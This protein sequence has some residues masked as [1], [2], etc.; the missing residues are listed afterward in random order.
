MRLPD[1]DDNVCGLKSHAEDPPQQH[2]DDARVGQEPHRHVD[3]QPGGAGLTA[4]VPQPFQAEVDHSGV[5]LGHQPGLFGGRQEVLRREQATVRRDDAGECLVSRHRV[6]AQ[7][8]HRLDADPHQTL[9][10]RLSGKVDHAH[11]V[12]GA[13]LE[14]GREEVH[15]VAAPL[16]GQVHGQ[17]GTAQQI[18]AGGRGVGRLSHP[19]RCAELVQPA[20]GVEWLIERGTDTLG[21]HRGL[22]GR[23]Q[24]VAHHHELVASHAGDH[25]VAPH[26][27][28]DAPRHLFEHAVAD[29]VAVGVVDVLEPVEVDEHDGHGA[30]LAPQ[31]RHHPRQVAHQDRT[32]GQARQWVVGG[33]VSQCLFRLAECRDVI[34]GHD[35]HPVLSHVGD[36]RRSQRNPHDS[37]P[38]S[39]HPDL[40]APRRVQQVLET[41]P[42]HH[43][44]IG[45]HEF[46]QS[47][48]QDLVVP[49]AQELQEGFADR[50]DAARLPLPRWWLGNVDHQGRRGRESEGEVTHT[51]P[52]G[53]RALRRLVHGLALHRPQAN[54]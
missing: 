16:L 24:G 34:Q 23:L 31:P 37:P 44:V 6:V 18:L 51:S 40:G 32:V 14:V 42:E 33:T 41:G 27:Q 43:L 3:A 28:A 38:G 9:I 8:E 50:L 47:V 36:V 25:V 48:A 13:V 46:L 7:V 17:V 30:R 12:S 29:P 26:C 45:V 35:Q 52:V 1:F 49:G 19:H 10:Q 53:R 5:D 39:D 21:D 22:R 4:L 2:V 20:V 15:T 11:P 54:D